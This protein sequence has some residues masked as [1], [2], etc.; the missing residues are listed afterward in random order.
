MKEETLHDLLSR[1]G[2]PLSLDVNAPFLATDPGKFWY[3]AEGKINLSGTQAVADLATGKVQDFYTFKAGELFFGIRQ[4]SYTALALLASPQEKS[5]VYEINIADFRRE[6]PPKY[7]WIVELEVLV[8]QW[9]ITLFHTI[10]QAFIKKKQDP[11]K[12]IA[13]GFSGKFES[14]VLIASEIP[15]V[16]CTVSDASKLKFHGLASMQSPT[17]EILIPLHR[18]V[19]AEILGSV[20]IA[21]VPSEGIILQSNF[22]NGLVAFQELVMEIQGMRLQNETRKEIDRLILKHQKA[23]SYLGELLNQAKV[24]LNDNKKEGFG[25]EFTKTQS[26]IFNALQIVANQQDI[27]LTLPPDILEAE[28]PLEEISRHSSVRYREIFLEGDWFKEDGGTFLGFLQNQKEPVAM[29]PQKNGSYLIANPET[30][31]KT[32]L[33]EK[34]KNL[35]QKSGF[36]LYKPMNF[37]IKG[38]LPLMKFCVLKDKSDYVYYLFLGLLVTVLG[39]ISPFFTSIIFD[40]IILNAEKDQLIYVGLGIGMA[41]LAAFLFEITQSLAMLRIE[42]KMDGTLQ[43]GVWDKILN[44]PVTFFTQFS[45]GDLANRSLGITHIRKELSGI[46]ITSVLGAVFSS[47]NLV[48]LFYYSPKLALIAIGIVSIQ[49][50]LNFFFAKI[51]IRD[52]TELVERTGR[53]EGIVLQMLS[54]IQKFRVSGTEHKAFGHWFK[55]YLPIKKVGLKLAKI[56]NIQTL[57]NTYFFYGTLMVLYIFMAGYS[58]HAHMTLGEFLAFNAAFGIF[59]GSINDM[60][61]A[62][63]GMFDIVPMYERTKP[64]LETPVENGLVNEIPPP[65]KGSLE[66]NHLS[67]RY[68]KDGPLILDD[69]SIEIKSGEYVA[70][71]GPSGSGKST[72][73]RLILGFNPPDSGNIYYDGHN[74]NQLDARKV[75]QQLGVVL[76]NGNLM[77]GEIYR[78]IIGSSNSLTVDDAWAAARL[79]AFDK[80][81]ESMPMKMFTMV[82]ESGG[83]ISGGQK[84]RLMIA[85]ALVHNPRILIFDE[86]T[87]ALDN[88]TQAIVTQ[89]LDQLETTRIVVAHR[90]STI[91][92]AHTIYYLEAGKVVEKGNYGEL[93]SLKGKFFELANRQIE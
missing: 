53:M 79:A 87:S 35:V 11:D 38:L 82:S 43:A 10:D 92:G 13:P 20:E 14:G 12:R 1:I 68:D 8:K 31:E 78:N 91:I 40:S 36:M 63:I 25:F 45:A 2:N 30:G 24:V 7:S 23:D 47:I 22:W 60:S 84:Q 72:L 83:T 49:I 26:S 44:L 73:L 6:L 17:Q 37:E 19:C 50:L 71:V 15:L 46:A 88:H 9:I 76:Q 5:L 33:N 18:N 65:L 42:S 62:L 41:G 70:F 74:L 61:R 39:M 86:A 85:R 52:Q 56:Q 93:M 29:I 80:D 4:T 55:H 3:I 57:V 16:W 59:S 89:S 28:D 32:I 81:V 51:Q 66:I 54:G 58:S 48:L 77:S 67:F 27:P 69:V 64:I 34:N 21:A 75:R 90:L